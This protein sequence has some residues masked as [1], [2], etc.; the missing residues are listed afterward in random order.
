ML[1]R[2]D[3]GKQFRS[4]MLRR[5]NRGERLEN[6]THCQL[7]RRK[8]FRCVRTV[9]KPNF[10]LTRRTGEAAAS[11]RTLRVLQDLRRIAGYG[12]AR[13][14]V[15]AMLVSA[16]RFGRTGGIRRRLLPRNARFEHSAR[17]KVS[18]ERPQE[19]MSQPNNPHKLTKAAERWLGGGAAFGRLQL[20]GVMAAA[21]RSLRIL[22]QSRQPPFR[23]EVGTVGGLCSLE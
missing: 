19:F 22:V 23:S 14:A 11:R 13:A 21:H 3:P 16:T 2:F 15:Q 4:R 10:V 7:D 5:S 6:R 1:R 9:G 17:L 8:E 12:I 18:R 20:H